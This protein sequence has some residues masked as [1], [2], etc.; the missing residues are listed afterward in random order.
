ML[1]VTKLLVAILFVACNR[2]AASDAPSE[3]PAPLTIPPPPVAP[4]PPPS[5]TAPPEETPAPSAS[6]SAGAPDKPALPSDYDR[7]RAAAKRGEVGKV[8]HILEIKVRAGRGSLEEARLLAGVCKAHRDT[9]C[10]QDVKAKYP[11]L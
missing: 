4:P 7:A 9:A 11:S 1:C 10:W 2:P 5:V 6:A 3:P 8:R